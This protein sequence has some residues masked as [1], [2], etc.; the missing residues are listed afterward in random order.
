MT[1]APPTKT[2]MQSAVIFYSLLALAM[3]ATGW[4]MIWLLQH[5]LIAWIAMANHWLATNFIEKLGYAGVFALMFI[6]SSF[7]PFPSEIVIPP[8]GSLAARDP[9]WN[10]GMV[11]LMGVLGSLGGALF[12]YWLA[13]RLGRP[14]MMMLIHRFGRYFHLS[15]VGY[16]AAEKFFL[17]HGAV[18]TFTGRL[19]PGIRQLISLP[20]GLA[21]MPLSSFV[22]FTT[23]GAG[24]WV[25]ILALIGYWFGSQPEL[26]NATIK[27]YSRWLGLA[28]VLAL[29][30]YLV[31]LRLRSKPE[32][33][34]DSTT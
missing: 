2:G 29:G 26:I 9:S 14:L 30:L 24:I 31:F 18:S 28:G 32:A 3:G 1:N 22:F 25:V 6:E 8:A 21:S 12:N 23:L 16:L 11:I 4:G 33:P 13:R 19:I 15:E 34:S 20:A 17:R 5:D 27:E 7:V 10:L